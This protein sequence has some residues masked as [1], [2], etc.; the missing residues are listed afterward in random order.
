MRVVEWGWVCGVG[1][2]KRTEFVG[3]SVQQIW[4]VEEVSAGVWVDG[5][6][7]GW[8]TAYEG[9]EC[10][11]PCVDFKLSRSGAASGG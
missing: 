7:S 1:R 8:G 11:Q 6:L 10:C 5:C 2:L 3:I 4:N 9:Q